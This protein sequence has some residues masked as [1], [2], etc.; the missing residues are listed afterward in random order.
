MIVIKDDM[1][2]SEVIEVVHIRY[3]QQKDGRD[4]DQFFDMD[5]HLIF[6]SKPVIEF[7]ESQNARR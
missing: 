1:H 2:Y 6:Q 7:A 5:G 3:F 4:A